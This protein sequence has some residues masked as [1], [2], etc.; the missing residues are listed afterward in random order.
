MVGFGDVKTDHRVQ[1]A[2][3]LG[4]G[5]CLLL[6]ACGSTEVESPAEIPPA[7]YTE[8]DTPEPV[9]IQGY[10]SDIMEPFFSR[11]GK[12]LF[13]NDMGTDNKDIFYATYDENTDTFTFAG[14]IAVVNTPAVEGV[15]TLDNNYRFYY[16][17][18][19]NYPP[20]TA[21]ILDTI[22]VG[23]FDPALPAVV[24]N[25][26]VV[27]GL[28][29]QTLGHLN[30]DVEVDPTGSIL[31]Y[32]D[33]I[34]SGNAFPD[35]SNFVYAVDSGSGFVKQADSPVIFGNINT[36]DLEYAACI[37]Q[38]GLEFF[39]TR[40]KL[41]T[42]DFGMY[43]ATRSSVSS[44]FGIARQLD[45][46]SGFVEAPTLSPDEKQLYYHR[47]NPTTNIFELYRVTRP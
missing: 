12:Y 35:V 3:V 34:F 22:Y 4:L 30:F 13:F 28:G 14:A 37:S 46:V 1:R 8:F 21:N 7:N 24:A 26:A 39:F 47:L 27:P 36:G 42:L 29:E 40:L 32:V 10:D 17:S 19:F 31:Y 25:L 11:D 43:R 33:G 16:I 2:A 5:F 45:Q 41:A 9:L 23:D 44:A 6:A 18:T 20:A 15:P 38:D